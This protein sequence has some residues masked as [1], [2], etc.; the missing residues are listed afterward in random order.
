MFSSYC[1]IS[2]VT[3][4]RLENKINQSKKHFFPGKSAISFK[5]NSFPGQ[6]NSRASR[7]HECVMDKLS[8][9][10]WTLSSVKTRESSVN[11][12][13]SGFSKLKV[14][15]FVNKVKD[16]D[17][18]LICSRQKLI[19]SPTF[20][21]NSRGLKWCLVM[22]CK[23]DDYYGPNL[24]FEFRSKD[25]R[26]FKIDVSMS[27]SILNR[28]EEKLHNKT[29]NFYVE[30][31]KKRA[32]SGFLN[33]FLSLNDL[34]D[35]RYGLV[36]NDELN[37]MCEY[38]LV[39]KHKI[40]KV[41]ENLDLKSRVRIL[42]GF[43]KQWEQQE[44]GDLLLAAPCNRVILTHRFVLKARCPKFFEALRHDQRESKTGLIRV[45]DLSFQVLEKMLRFMY[46]GKVESLDFETVRGLL[47]AAGRYEIED[48][49]DN[50]KEFLLKNLS[51]G[52]ARKTLE[53]CEEYGLTDIQ[54]HV[55]TFIKANAKFIN[56][57]GNNKT[58][59]SSLKLDGETHERHFFS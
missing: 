56:H 7:V 37:I 46:S 51:V 13:I 8:Q 22:F 17:D 15:E 44:D 36:D 11:W 6:S 27:I 34:F 18:K 2:L 30:H 21:I 26:Y 23:K 1:V 32:Y 40:S 19:E 43:E 24:Y 33:N 29:Y 57:G 49:R 48:L 3:T 25:F 20:S 52:N 4:R 59:N 5:K 47:E 14:E 58:V 53:L 55:E 16:T 50:C 35:E 42:E 28:D 54:P 31:S 39:P 41:T 45:E 38:K 10:R 12:K 9:R